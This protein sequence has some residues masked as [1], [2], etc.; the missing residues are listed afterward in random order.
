MIILEKKNGIALH[1]TFS[2]TTLIRSDVSQLGSM[3]HLFP[4]PDRA[5]RLDE[6]TCICYR[7]CVERE[8]AIHRAELKQKLMLM[9][10]I[11]SHQ[12]N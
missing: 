2:G 9:H 10:R 6:S 11:K 4:F 1:T 12:V 3:L 8:N 5:G 7:T